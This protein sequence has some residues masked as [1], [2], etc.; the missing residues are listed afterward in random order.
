MTHWPRMARVWGP[1]PIAGNRLVAQRLAIAWSA[2]AWRLL[3][4]R[5]RDSFALWAAKQRTW[6]R[7]MHTSTAAPTQPATPNRSAC[8]ARIAG[9]RRGGGAAERRSGEARQGGEMAG[10]NGER[11]QPKS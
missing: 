2:A 6:T 1:R 5:A 8:V 10:R 7:L 11:W 9:Q 4:R 3:I